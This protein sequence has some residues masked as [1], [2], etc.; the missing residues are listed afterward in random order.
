[1]K[2]LNEI[3]KEAFFDD[4][5]ED[6]DAPVKA[7]IEGWINKHAQE[8]APNIKIND[9]LTLDAKFVTIFL[10]ENE[11][12]PEYIRFKQARH[13]DIYGEIAGDPIKIHKDLLPPTMKNLSIN[14]GGV[15]FDDKLKLDVN[16]LTIYHARSIILS[17]KMTVSG[18]LNLTNCDGLEKLENIQ[19][20]KCVNIP[21]AYAAK[22]FRKAYNY[23][24]DLCMNGFG[25]Y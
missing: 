9:D 17:K 21:N 7:A 11:Q 20:V 22:I 16:E 25:P 12:I 6:K 5:L 13:L 3:V 18:K 23:K 2:R 4:H 10:E 8:D 14:A 19:G 24:G 1:M 15:E